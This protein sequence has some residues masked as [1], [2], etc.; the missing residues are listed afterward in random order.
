MKLFSACCCLR[1]LASYSFE[2]KYVLNSEDESFEEACAAIEELLDRA[3]ELPPNFA[4]L[5]RGERGL[6]HDGRRRRF[7]A[8][9]RLGAGEAER[10]L[11]TERPAGRVSWSYGIP[12]SSLTAS[13]PDA[14]SPSL[15]W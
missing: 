14:V 9:R 13:P 7:V 3:N 11:D 8:L 1:Q 2:T 12:M 6:D 10:G 4:A 5:R 15:M